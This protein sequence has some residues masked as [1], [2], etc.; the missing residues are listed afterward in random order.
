MNAGGPQLLPDSQVPDDHPAHTAPAL[1]VALGSATPS[2]A[3]VT[4]HGVL[5]QCWDWTPDLPSLRQGGSD[6]GRASWLRGDSFRS[7]FLVVPLKN[8]YII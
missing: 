7:S 6:R 1:T 5:G 2:T 3:A 4:E 8:I